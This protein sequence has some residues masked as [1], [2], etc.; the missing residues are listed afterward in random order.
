MRS[1]DIPVY[2]LEEFQRLI[3]ASPNVL[4]SHPCVVRGFTGQWAASRGWTSFEQLTD[5]FGSFPVTA[6]APQFVT[7]K[8]ARMCQ[9]KT[10]FGTYLRYVQD[11]G[12][13]EE[14]FEGPQA[15]RPSCA[16]SICRSI[17]ATCAS[18]GTRRKRSSPKSIRWCPAQWNIGTATFLI[19]TSP[20]TMCGC[21]S[22]W[23]AR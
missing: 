10:D 17:A 4:A 16:S 22:A 12:R 3:A 7:H 13:V 14:L 8:H 1:S 23:L 20:G 11:P 9:V 5:A 19:I 21:T 18:S 2:E 6:G 15:M